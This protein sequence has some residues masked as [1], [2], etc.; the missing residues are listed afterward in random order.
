MKEENTFLRR[1]FGTLKKGGH[2][3]LQK[4]KRVKIGYKKE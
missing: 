2:F 3:K 1:Q 4:I